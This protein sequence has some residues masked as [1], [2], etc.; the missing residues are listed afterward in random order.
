MC[1]ACMCVIG[2]VVIVFVL[3][4]SRRILVNFYN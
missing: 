2:F 3:F 4:A 1:C